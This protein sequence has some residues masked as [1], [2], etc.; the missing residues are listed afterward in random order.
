MAQSRPPE[1]P[2]ESGNIIFFILMAIVLIGL[3]TAAL[4]STGIE[5]ASI[6]HED[7]AIKVAQV[8]QHAAEVEHG[9]QLVMQ[10]GISE[11]DISFAH[12]DAP[13]QYGSYN[14]N[15]KAEIFNP[16]GGGATWR[17]PP[18]GI[19]YS[20]GGAAAWEYY[21]D[22]NAPNV[23]S[24]KPDLIA[25][26]PEVSDQ[27]CDE[28]NRTRNQTS[29]QPTDN[30][31]S[32]IDNAA[33]RSTLRFGSANGWFPAVADD[34]DPASFTTLPAPEACVRCGAVPYYYHVLMAR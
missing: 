24:D 12:P 15:P 19:A 18:S 7:L 11:Q 21:G 26:L 6:S 2:G 1:R 29:Q 4:R 9:V 34:M 30:S 10:N 5:T 8:R 33:T 31:G 28:V 17:T 20:S 23:G 3:V 25:V 16:A 32:C 27:F 13:T 22:T 14:A